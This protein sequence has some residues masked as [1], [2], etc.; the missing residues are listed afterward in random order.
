MD[1][2]RAVK[3]APIPE[4]PEYYDKKSSFPAESASALS[5]VLLF[6]QKTDGVDVVE[7]NELEH[8]L[9]CSACI[10]NV[11]CGFN[12]YLWRAGKEG[13]VVEF[14]KRYGSSLSFREVVGQALA[15]YADEPVPEPPPP[16]AEM[17]LDDETVAI[18]RSMLKI[19]DFEEFWEALRLLAD[20]SAAASNHAKLLELITLE[21]L[22]AFFTSSAARDEE[23]ER[24]AAI[25]LAN[26]C[27]GGTS[28]FAVGA[29]LSAPQAKAQAYVVEQL[30]ELF[31]K[32][33]QLKNCPS[34]TKRHILRCIDSLP[35]VRVSDR[36]RAM[37][38]Q[39]A[40]AKD[41]DAFLRTSLVRFIPSQ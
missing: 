38:S 34:V 5:D 20:A 16:F 2:L 11:S 12:V 33:V 32:F 1:S 40:G 36:Q 35:V 18:V 7:S 8:N 24:C 17:T 22:G 19:P 21:Q 15:K 27:N 25:I 31:C 30:F 13:Y 39:L 6:L 41:V 3:P 10:N 29:P 4:L 23:L 37:C 26:L 9:K 14:Q 28:P